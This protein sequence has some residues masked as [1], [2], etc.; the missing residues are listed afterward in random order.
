MR[1]G[2]IFMRTENIYL[3]TEKYFCVLRNIS[4]Y[5]EIFL[6]TKKYI[7]A[8]SEIYLRTEKYFCVLKIC[9]LYSLYIYDVSVI[10]NIFPQ[11]YYISVL[12]LW[13]T[14]VSLLIPLFYIKIFK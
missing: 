7:S 2:E 4:A 1:T 11:F 5:L 14:V 6:R 12:P 9:L 10:R 3:R 8:Y 13:A